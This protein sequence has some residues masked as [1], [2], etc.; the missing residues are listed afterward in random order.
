MLPVTKMKQGRNGMKKAFEALKNRFFGTQ[1][2]KGR[3]EVKKGARANRHVQR[4]QLKAMVRWE[5]TPIV[6]FK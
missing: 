6:G 5:Q 2:E 3:V 4:G 1:I